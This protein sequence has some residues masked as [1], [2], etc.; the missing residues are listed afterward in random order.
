MDQIS[1]I[2]SGASYP[3]SKAAEVK[4]PVEVRQPEEPSQA[5]VRDE[6]I[7]EEKREPSGLYWLGKDEDGQ[8]KVY[9]D[10]PE[11]DKEEICTCD[12]DEVDREIEEL[13]KEQAELESQIGSETDE[14][15]R[16]N[17]AREL[18]QIEGELHQKDT[19]AYR[20]RHATFTNG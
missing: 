10:D 2:L 4:A 6:Y 7:P 13:K 11:Q 8:P 17:L 18:A 16:E 19:D 12:T 3:V 1:G 15:K 14:I 5:P 20:R 9:F